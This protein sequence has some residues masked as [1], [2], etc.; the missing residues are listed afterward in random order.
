MPEFDPNIPE[1]YLREKQEEPMSRYYNSTA[2]ISGGAYYNSESEQA[3][4]TLKIEKIS[5]PAE[6]NSKMVGYG[7]KI[8]YWSPILPDDRLT[9]GLQRGSFPNIYYEILANGDLPIGVTNNRD[10]DLNRLKQQ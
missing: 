3:Q 7:D 1:E 6:I 8:L 5:G 9:L 10:V 4:K 2:R